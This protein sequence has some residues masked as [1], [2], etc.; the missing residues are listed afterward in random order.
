MKKINNKIKKSYAEQAFNVFNIV[1]LTVLSLVTLYPFLYVVFASL[2]NPAEFLKDSSFLL[3]PAGFSL[4]A[5]RRVL[6]KP[7]IYTGYFNTLFYVV[8]GTS[9]SMLLTMSL[10]YVLSRKNLYFTNAI[11]MLIVFTMYFQGGL[12]PK[13][14]VVRSLGIT[15]TRMA[16]I[17]PMAIMTSNLI[18][19]RTAF[20]GVPDV[21]EE[22]AKVDGMGPL[23]ILFKIMIPLAAPTIAVLV[24]YY[25]VYF[26]NDWFQAAIYLRDSKLFPL[27]LYL[28]EILVLNNQ[29]DMLI[30]SQTAEQMALSETIKYATIM[31]ATVPI[32]IL[33]PFLQKYFTKGVMIGAVKG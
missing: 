28:R 14:L 32:L 12:I 20:R 23:G 3:R 27:Q 6:E 22:A 11:M 15:D 8:V 33:Y 26:W 29:D 4:E 10:G 24:L 9:V 1:F 16:I 5:Y 2:S 17:F 7:E 21:L 31:V 30:A 25:A 13:Y 19:M 18:I